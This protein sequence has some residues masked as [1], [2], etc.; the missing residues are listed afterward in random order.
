MWKA[1]AILY[2]IA[3]YR[4]SKHS[5]AKVHNNFWHVSSKISSQCIFNLAAIIIQARSIDSR[6]DRLDWI[7]YA[8]AFS[9]VVETRKIVYQSK[10]CV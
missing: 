1:V 7:F 2:Q 3:E 4:T 6:I 9:I 10:K 5:I 8:R